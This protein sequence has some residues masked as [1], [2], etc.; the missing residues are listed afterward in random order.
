[1]AKAARDMQAQLRQLRFEAGW[2]QRI[3]CSTKENKRY[4][5]LLRQG[6][7]LPDGVFAY[8]EEEGDWGFYT[9]Y[10]PALSDEEK[11]EYLRLTQHQYLKTIR[12]CLLILTGLAV[13]G[14]CVAVVWLLSKL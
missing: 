8:Q 11:A 10:V 2:M 5:E 1:M 7:T 14:A 13:F 4:R 12:N 6:G 9:V 3:P